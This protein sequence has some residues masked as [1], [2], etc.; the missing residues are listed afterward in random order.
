MENKAMTKAKEIVRLKATGK[1]GY[2]SPLHT[3]DR[4]VQDNIFWRDQGL[5][6]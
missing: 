6:E 2:A 5:T 4:E 1:K 3:E